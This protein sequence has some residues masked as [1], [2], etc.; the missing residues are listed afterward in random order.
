MGHCRTRPCAG[1]WRLISPR[2]E[3]W[4]PHPG[5]DTP[6]D[7]LGYSP[8]DLVPFS[9]DTWLRLVA[10][11]NMEHL[12]AVLTGL[13]SGVLLLWLV[14]GAATWRLRLAEAL[15]VP[16][17]LW[18]AWAFLSQALGTL[19]WAADWLALGFAVQGL[20]L[21]LST[22]IPPRAGDER[23]RGSLLAAW[24]LMASGVAL[25]PMAQL[26]SGQA[27]STL[28]WFGSAPTPTA[29]ATLALAVL[30]PGPRAWLLLP[31]PLLWCMLASAVQG[32]FGDPL[33]PLPAIAA[34]LAVLVRLLPRA[35]RPGPVRAG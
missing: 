2:S 11:Y 17:W 13:G 9:R 4:R 29:V 20:L 31:V 7:W 33:W 15:L 24:C 3:P 16:S 1:A 22:L 12:P 34:L 30:I 28:S 25:L 32:V 27:P 26:V 14:A 10:D 8:A 23:W 6:L 5:S 35:R 21:L 18:I 19:L